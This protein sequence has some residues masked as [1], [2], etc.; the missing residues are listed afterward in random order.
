MRKEGFGMWKEAYIHYQW[1]QQLFKSE[2]KLRG[3][4]KK[5]EEE[6]KQGMQKASA[7]HQQEHQIHTKTHS[8]MMVKYF[9][10]RVAPGVHD[11]AAKKEAFGRWKEENIHLLWEEQVRLTDRK[12]RGEHETLRLAH[13][14]EV[15]KKRKLIEEIDE[16]LAEERKLHDL[17]K[18]EV[19]LHHQA[20]SDLIIKLFSEK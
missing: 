17:H 13:E 8:D 20:R 14:E 15:R 18:E 3:E 16:E 4:L 10:E 19:K 5:R 12:L 7:L 1:E 9:S 2:E 11:V 6:V